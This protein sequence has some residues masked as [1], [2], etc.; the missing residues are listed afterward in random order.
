MQGTYLSEGLRSENDNPTST[1]FKDGA[2]IATKLAMTE[3]Q[4]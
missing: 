4:S 2:G 1:K 3:M